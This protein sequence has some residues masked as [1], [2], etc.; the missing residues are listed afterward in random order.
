VNSIAANTAHGN[1][2]KLRSNMC[3][4]IIVFI[5]GLAE[6]AEHEPR[7]AQDKHRDDL[8]CRDQAAEV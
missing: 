4:A 1:E 5:T 6:S 3:P 8:R 2:R 7:K